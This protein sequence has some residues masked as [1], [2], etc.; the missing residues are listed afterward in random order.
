MSCTRKSNRKPWPSLSRAPLAN[1]SAC[2]SLATSCAS[3][4]GRCPSLFNR[5]L[6]RPRIRSVEMTPSDFDCAR[7]EVSSSTTPLPNQSSERSSLRFSI[8][9]TARVRDATVAGNPLREKGHLHTKISRSRTTAPRTANFQMFLGI[10]TATL[11]EV[12]ETGT[13]S[14]GLEAATGCRAAA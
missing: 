7:S 2:A 5:C 11:A 12:D 4:G 13:E 14:T 8:S 3:L 9:T 10:S 6:I 1:R